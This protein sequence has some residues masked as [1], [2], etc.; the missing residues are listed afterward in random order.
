[1]LRSKV[2]LTQASNAKTQYIS[3]PAKVVSD[4]QY[5][6]KG[7]EDL[8]LEVHPLGF[9]ILSKGCKMLEQPRCPECKG[10]EVDVERP[11]YVG[12]PFD[13]ENIANMEIP[14]SCGCG[15]R[16]SVKAA[17]LP[18]VDRALSLK[19]VRDANLRD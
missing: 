3:I 16:F 12:R 10:Y 5:P 7:A 6:F 15:H 14:C 19:D 8:V 1:M 18:F 2:S 9:M 13:A 4:S 11:M 17:L